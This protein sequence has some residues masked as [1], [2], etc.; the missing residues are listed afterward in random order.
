MRKS[1][2]LS[3]IEFNSKSDAKSF[4][5]EMLQRYEVGEKVSNADAVHLE[6]LLQLHTEHK[7]KVGSGVDYFQVMKS[8][9]GTPCFCIVR[10]DGS[11]DDFS[12]GHCIT[13][14]K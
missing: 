11:S 9:Y 6:A 10:A 3:T 14:K 12:Y 8:Q 2:I 1:L 7:D 5:K 13:P 4:F